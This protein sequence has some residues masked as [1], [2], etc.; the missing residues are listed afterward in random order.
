MGITMDSSDSDGSSGYEF[1]DQ[2][3]LSGR[4]KAPLPPTDRRPSLCACGFVLVFVGAVVA[5]SVYDWRVLLGHRAVPQC[6]PTHFMPYKSGCPTSRQCSALRPDATRGA[7]FVRADMSWYFGALA[8]LHDSAKLGNMSDANLHAHTTAPPE[9]VRGYVRLE[10]A[11]EKVTPLT[12]HTQP[13]LALALSYFCCVTP[14]EMTTL[15]HV[16]LQWAMGRRN[17]SLPVRFDRVECRQTRS[18]AAEALLM[19]DQESQ[20]NLMDLNHDLQRT[21]L[22]AGVPVMVSRERQLPFHMRIVGFETG[23]VKSILEFLEAIAE[24]VFALNRHISLDA[25]ISGELTMG[26]VDKLDNNKF[27]S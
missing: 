1:V 14:D 8:G 24:T 12:V 16:A 6:S 5:F 2:L 22:E 17:L 23:G 9:L 13:K 18:N 3:L 15:K 7:S 27:T 20:Q 26:H 11:L 4:A 25:R 19:A 10:D 21:L